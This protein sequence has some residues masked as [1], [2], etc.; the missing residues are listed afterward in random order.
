[1]KL[2]CCSKSFPH[3][4]ATTIT[5]LSEGGRQQS[6]L[7]DTTFP[8][9]WSAETKSEIG[10]SVCAGCW[11]LLCRCVQVHRHHSGAQV[12]RQADRHS[13]QCQMPHTDHHHHQQTTSFPRTGSRGGGRGPEE[14]TQTGTEPVPPWFLLGPVSRIWYMS[15]QACQH[16][17]G[18]HGSDTILTTS[19]ITPLGSPLQCW[20]A[21]SLEHQIPMFWER[22]QE[23]VGQI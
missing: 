18:H 6:L 11:W 22:F 4:Q 8:G 15:G 1:M 10:G 7:V 2:F 19:S 21:R 20:D 3:N 13:N 9:E 12:H 16:S 14:D 5:A 23:V 17:G